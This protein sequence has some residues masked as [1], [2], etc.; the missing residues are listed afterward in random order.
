MIRQG[1]GGGFVDEMVRAGY[2]GVNFLGDY[3]ILPNLGRGYRAFHAALND[4]YLRMHPDKSR[5][6]AGLAMGNLYVACEGIH[7]GDIVLSGRPGKGYDYGTVVGPYEYF[8][9]TNLPH[10]R[11]VDWQGVIPRVD[12]SSELA[13]SAGSPSTVFSL[14]AHSTELGRLAGSV[15]LAEPLVRAAVREE[16]QEKLAFQ[17]EKQLEDFLVH[18]WDKTQL[19]R[20]YDIYEDG[21][22]NGRQFMTETGP[23]DILAV[24]KD[25]K[26]LLVIELKKGR[27]SDAV[28]GQIQRYMGYVHAELLEP[29]QTVEGLIIAGEDD[30]RISHALRVNNN[31]RFMK[32]RVDFHLES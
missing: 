16:V 7:E 21:E 4:E 31:I 9:G 10:R 20:D 1:R 25:K 28:V 15:S 18:N 30:I 2:V 29:G 8:P 23:M 26:R 32:Y 19:G 17:L 5:I 27:T 3:D 11:R 22:F 14:S 6:T 13:A 12:M 24:S